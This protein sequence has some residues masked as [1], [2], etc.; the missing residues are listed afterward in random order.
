MAQLA[1]VS[2]KGGMVVRIEESTDKNNTGNG[3]LASV[4]RK[5]GMVVRIEESTDK[6]NTGNGA[7]ASVSR[8]GCKWSSVRVGLP[9]LK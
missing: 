3:A 2:R 6:N 8:K 4:S 5:G 9:R 7:L 1:S